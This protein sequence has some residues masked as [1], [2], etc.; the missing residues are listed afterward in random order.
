MKAGLKSSQSG[1]LVDFGLDVGMQI[2]GLRSPARYTGNAWDSTPVTFISGLGNSRSNTNDY[3]QTSSASE[4]CI[5]HVPNG[6]GRAVT[7][8]RR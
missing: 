3:A 7:R 6:D 4:G 5:A 1:V 2:R 8:A